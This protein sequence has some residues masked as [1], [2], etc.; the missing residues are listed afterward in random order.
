[1]SCGIIVHVG[2]IT[3]CSVDGCHI[4]RRSAQGYCL[5]HY[6]R[7]KNHGTTDNLAP[8]PLTSRT[9]LVTTCSS[10]A[11]HYPA[12]CDKHYRRQKT[13]G[14]TEDEDYRLLLSSRL[15]KRYNTSGYVIFNFPEHSNA[16][17]NGALLEH[18]YVMSKHLGRPLRR[19]ENV[20]HK[21][22]IRDD[23]CLKNLELWTTQQPPGKRVADLVH[24]AR[25]LIELYGEE[26]PE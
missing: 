8:K 10:S 19:G 9:C 15:G 2:S 4:G 5:K 11:R 12:F 17:V 21:N 7:W 1:M 14:V 16:A 25:E 24:W 6:K 23:N 26:V 20:H 3:E 18:V 22:G 13:F